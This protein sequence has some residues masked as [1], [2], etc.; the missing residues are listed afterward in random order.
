REFQSD[1]QR[2][3]R[4]PRGIEIREWVDGG[5]LAEPLTE[6]QRKAAKSLARVY[7][8]LGA[9]GSAI[10]HDVLVHC[11]TMKQI[12]ARRGAKG[13][14]WE[15]FFGTRFRECLDTM[16]IVYGFSMERRA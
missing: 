2:A 12:A 11:Y 8:A 16:A 3:E 15:E 10:V 9:N 4:G 6:S 7:Y 13:R 5:E 1:F 14:T